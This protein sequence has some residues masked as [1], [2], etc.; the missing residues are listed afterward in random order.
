MEKNALGRGLSALIPEGH[1]EK[2]KIQTVPI[3]KLEPSS[4]QPRKFFSEARIKELGESIREKGMIQPIL[5]RPRDERFEIIAGERRFRAA[6]MIG[7]GEVPVIIKQVKDGDLLEISLIENIQREDLNHLEEARA[8]KRLV[9]EF[10]MTHEMI[11]KRVSKDRATI[12]NTLRLLELPVRIQALLEEN[13]ISMGHARSLL[14]LELEKDQWRITQQI[15]KK[16]L[17]VRQTEQ[18]VR[19]KLTKPEGSPRRRKDIHL[20]DIEEK[21]QH[22]FGTRVKIYQGK[23]RGKLVIEY[24]SPEDLNRILG[25]IDR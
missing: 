5:V 19:A 7:F 20:Q 11:S 13:A 14:S 3:E 15:V 18:L 21:L 6:K 10:G 9:E 23:K 17:S 22:R 25:I 1:Q 2:E 12:T 8:F 4:F 24:F 16:G